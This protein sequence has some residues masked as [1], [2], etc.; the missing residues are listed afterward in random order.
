MEEAYDIVKKRSGSKHR[1]TRLS[2]RENSRPIDENS[3]TSSEV[4]EIVLVSNHLPSAVAEIGIENNIPMIPVKN[5]VPLSENAELLENEEPERRIEENPIENRELAPLTPSPLLPIIP[6]IALSE[7][8]LVSNAVEEP[9][10]YSERPVRLRQVPN[11]LS[12]FAPGQAYLLQVPNTVNN[13]PFINNQPTLIRI[14]LNNPVMT[15]FVHPQM[16]FITPSCRQPIQN[17]APQQFIF[18]RPIYI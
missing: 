1:R 6:E 9:I 15:Q 16:P 18:R 3:E 14:P 12:Y 4:E 8:A 17:F 13:R 7:E 2:A 10:V 11:R 5:V